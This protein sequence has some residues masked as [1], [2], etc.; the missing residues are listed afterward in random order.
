MRIHVNMC[1]IPFVSMQESFM[2]SWRLYDD[3]DDSQSNR[4]R[5]MHRYEQYSMLLVPTERA[6]CS[7]LYL[8]GNYNKTDEFEICTGINLF[9]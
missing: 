1:I 7:L 8:S 9:F 3:N 2:F 4:T 5:G 6:V